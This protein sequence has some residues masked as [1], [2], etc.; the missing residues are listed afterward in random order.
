MDI[1]IVSALL[2]LAVVATFQVAMRIMVATEYVPEAAW[3]WAYP[4]LSRSSGN[5]SDLGSQTTRL[6]VVLLSLGLCVALALI[7]LSPWLIPLLFGSTY[8]TAVLPMQLMA[9]AIPLRYGA[10]VYGTALS[11]AG[12]QGV[13]TRLFLSAVLIGV[14]LEVALVSVAGLNGA[15]IA[16]FASSSLLLAAYFGSARRAWGTHLDVRPPAMTWIVAVATLLGVVV[17]AR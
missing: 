4:H 3:R 17:F 9:S 14:V 6:A 7:V 11:A 15:P 5:V 2:P 12:L 1:V 10:H 16:V 8:A 13:R